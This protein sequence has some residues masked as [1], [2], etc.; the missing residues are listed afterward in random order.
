MKGRDV[1]NA[2][3]KSFSVSGI[4]I[5]TSVNPHSA[6]GV[7]I[8]TGA[9]QRGM[10]HDEGMGQILL[11]AKGGRIEYYLSLSDESTCCFQRL[12]TGWQGFLRQ[13]F[14]C[15]FLYNKQRETN[16][17]DELDF[18][19]GFKSQQFYHQETEGF[20]TVFAERK[21]QTEGCFPS[22]FV[23]NVLPWKRFFH[24]SLCWPVRGAISNPMACH[25][26][27][28]LVKSVF[29]LENSR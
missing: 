26:T 22:I 28:F 4:N 19:P 18:R 13:S 24:C 23:P 1:R 5:T 10:A 21:G 12:N 3:F 25:Y 16:E 27:Q 14:K 29:P 20:L 9:R 17:N 2:V 15:L 7:R 11:E 8:L 6:R